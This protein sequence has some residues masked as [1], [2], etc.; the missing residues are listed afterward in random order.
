MDETTQWWLRKRSADRVYGPVNAETLVE[1]A[2]VGR[3]GLD[4][5]I[6]PDGQTWMR[7]AEFKTLK[8]EWWVEV[9]P[10]RWLGPLALLAVPLL[11][12]EQGLGRN[13]RVRRGPS[14]PPVP[15]DAALRGATLSS[16]DLRTGSA[17]VAFMDEARLK[18]ELARALGVPRRALRGNSKER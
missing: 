3:V 11:C 5:E 8:L 4:D 12:D 7:A 16:V 13:V 15:L 2:R 9:E 14:G 6:S 18:E 10:D 17:S 1:W